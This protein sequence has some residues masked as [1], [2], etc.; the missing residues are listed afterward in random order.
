MT[1]IEIKVICIIILCTMRYGG[2]DFYTILY[3]NWLTSV[4][5][6]S[7]LN[8]VLCNDTS[9]DLVNREVSEHVV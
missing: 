9:I 7:I 5:D 4:A 8:I 6:L 2:F 3:K 1:K